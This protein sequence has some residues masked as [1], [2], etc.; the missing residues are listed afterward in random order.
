MTAALLLLAVVVLA[1]GGR[2]VYSLAT[3]GR[4][5]AAAMSSVYDD[6]TAGVR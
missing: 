5:F 2:L 3:E 1:V 6:E 4:R